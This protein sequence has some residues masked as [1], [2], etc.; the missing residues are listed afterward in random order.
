MYEMCANTFFKE[1]L[2]TLQVFLC[3]LISQRVCA[4]T[5]TQL[6]GNIACNIELHENKL[7][8]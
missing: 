7:L 5:H 4:R 2:C 3:V 8:I 6:R 1:N